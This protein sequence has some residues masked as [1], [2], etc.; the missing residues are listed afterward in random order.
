MAHNAQRLA[1]RSAQRGV[2]LFIALIAMVVLSLAGVALIRAVDTSGS[3]AGNIAFREASVTA[4]NLAIEQAVD[5]L[6]VSKTLNPDTDVDNAHHYYGK[7]QPGE[8]P[9]GLP[10]VLAGT[11][12]TM[13]SAY[14][15]GAAD[16]YPT[17]N[18]EV[19]SV[20]ERI[21]SPAA[22]VPPA[23]GVLTF[24]EKTQYCDSQPPKVSPAKTSMKLKGPTLPPI[25][26][27]RVTVRIDLPG[28]NTA[29]YAQTMLH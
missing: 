4:V 20:I 27:Y 10:A 6:Y 1:T 18:A 15:F 16:V 29:T 3:A 19:R 26:L 22:P 17:T 21:C 14:P 13:K 25:P 5:W 28:T 7:L 9:N 8:L 2:V 24:I 23:P 11:Y 12:S